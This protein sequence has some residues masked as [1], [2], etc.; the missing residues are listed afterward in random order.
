M[1]FIPI[2]FSIILIFSITSCD[3]T[4]EKVGIDVSN[5][6]A[7]G[8]IIRFDEALLA[9]KS[10]AEITALMQQYP[11]YATDF[12]RV[13]P[14]NK[15]VADSLFKLTQNTDIQAFFKESQ[16]QFTNVAN[17]EAEFANA[18]KHI[19]YYYPTFKEPKILA[20]FTGL[21]SDLYVSDSLIIVSLESFIGKT[22]KYRPNQPTY[23]QNKYER[24]YIVPTVIHFLSMKY[25]KTNPADQ[26]LLSD[27]IYH[28]KADEFVFEM[29]PNVA[30]TLV[31]GYTDRQM[32][33]TWEAQ[34]LVYAHFVD[35]KLLFETNPFKKDKYMIERPTTNE[36]GPACPGRIGQWLG[37]RI[38]EKYRSENPSIS[39]QQLM[40]NTNAKEIFEKS[41]YRGER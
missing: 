26:T 20:T 9:A 3:S 31:L 39:F 25:I 1:K 34:D 19:K 16:A 15:A 29:M 32:D 36:V 38:T 23:I 14:N 11:R 27:M 5:I 4:S 18:F 35:N 22:A 17:L 28:G 7:S 30:D 13:T 6:K 41:K 2:F 12:L 24:Q 10:P 8:K 37:W 21:S 33:E 40:A